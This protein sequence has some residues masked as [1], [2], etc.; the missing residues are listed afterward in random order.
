MVEGCN[1]T[2]NVQFRMC[3]EFFNYILWCL[4]HKSSFENLGQGKNRKQTNNGS[5]VGCDNIRY[6]IKGSEASH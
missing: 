1:D 2:I 3:K 6:D 4:A 5:D